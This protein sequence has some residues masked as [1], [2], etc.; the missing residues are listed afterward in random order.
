MVTPSFDGGALNPEIRFLRA[1]EVMNGVKCAMTSFMLEREKQLI[2]E[3]VQAVLHRDDG[4]EW[5]RRFLILY[6]AEYRKPYE[7]VASQIFQGDLSGNDTGKD[8]QF[9]PY[10]LGQDKLAEDFKK[11][12]IDVDNISHMWIDP[13][14]LRSGKTVRK[15]AGLCWPLDGKFRHW[16]FG[17][18]GGGSCVANNAP[19]LRE[20]RCRE[21]LGRTLWN[22]KPKESGGAV[23]SHCSAVPDYSRFALDPSQQASIDL[24]LNGANQGTLFYD[25]IDQS[26]L[27]PLRNIITAGDR[28]RGFVFPKVDMTGKATTIFQMSAQMPQTIFQK[29][30]SRCNTKYDDCD[31]ETLS[32]TARV[33][34][35]DST[36][37]AALAEQREPVIVERSVTVQVDQP[38]DGIAPYSRD[39]NG[40]RP[41]RKIIKKRAEHRPEDLLTR[42]EARL[43]EAEFTPSQQYA[44]G[45]G[46]NGIL[47]LDDHR[48]VDYLALKDMLKKVVADQN[49]QVTYR[50]G[51]EVALDTLNLTATFQ[52]VLDMSAGTKHIFRFF[53]MVGPP[54]MGMKFDH[55]HTLKIS[56]RGAKKRGD[57]DGKKRLIAACKE[58]LQRGASNS[59]DFCDRP[60]AQMLEAIAQSLEQGRSGSGSS[61]GTE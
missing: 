48:D 23:A 51:P 4:D 32:P 34:Q 57:P 6:A 29:G 24:T 28:S 41:K 59:N 19:S 39:G 26:G 47:S 30:Q 53:P 49:E 45:C 46:S 44:R 9:N 58:R 55:F 18:S 56:L 13:R 43:I 36:L 25:L 31:D 27:G 8:N 60:E 3:R 17:G 35:V 52:M 15:L 61:S 42:E 22:Y 40:Y 7:K 2:D 14:V 20:R 11:K 54:Q 37:Q 21:Q 38:D 33:A 10:A 16:E 12:G 50:G 5:R 1:G